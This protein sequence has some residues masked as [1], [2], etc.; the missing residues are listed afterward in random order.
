VALGCGEPGAAEVELRF[1]A[2]NLMPGDYMVTVGLWADEAAEQP[3]DVRHGGFQLNVSGEPD[4]CGAV[5]YMPAR[6]ELTPEPDEAGSGDALAGP[7]AISGGRTGE[8]LTLTCGCALPAASKLVVDLLGETGVVA[9]SAFEDLV[10][11]SGEVKVSY[12]ALNLLPGWYDV[13]I[14]LRADAVEAELEGSLEVVGE[15]ADGA[16]LVYCPVRWVTG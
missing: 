9:R 15:V 11:G 12:Q 16:G 7:L 13:R 10:S 14:T 8:P 2:L 3:F 4:P 1:T 6:L 5:A